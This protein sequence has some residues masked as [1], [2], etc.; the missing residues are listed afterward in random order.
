MWIDENEYV[1]NSRTKNKKNHCVENIHLL[2]IFFNIGFSALS[3][4]QPTF[5]HIFSLLLT[6]LLNILYIFLSIKDMSVSNVTIRRE[7]NYE[8]Y[9]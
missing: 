2:N 9:L 7:K 6:L 4:A 3:M 8:I 5:P 1:E